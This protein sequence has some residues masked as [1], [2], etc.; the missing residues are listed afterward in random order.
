MNHSC[1]VLI[2]D[3][4]VFSQDVLKHFVESAGVAADCVS[5]GL[6]AVAVIREAAV[7]YDAVFVDQLMPVTDGMQTAAEIRQIGTKYAGSIPLIA[8]TADTE[9][10]DKR[11]FLSR[12]FQDYISKPVDV[13]QLGLIL[14]RW[15][16]DSDTSTIA[17]VAAIGDEELLR[18]FRRS[19]AKNI[20]ALLAKARAVSEENLH[21]YAIHVHGIKGSCRNIRA[22]DLANRANALE[23]AA[24]RRDL[25]Y[26]R[27]ENLD[28]I[29]AVE[30]LVAGIG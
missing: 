12:G 6:E 10:G 5:S 13:S 14:R 9:I 15:V 17:G 11:A 19:F 2:V 16:T 24:H 28:F 3:D 8:I 27:G 30:D 23:Q 21:D 1:R 26:I 18:E 4:V 22:D 20:P 29:A 25:D 7:L